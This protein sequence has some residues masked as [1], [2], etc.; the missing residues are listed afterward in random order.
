MKNY[1]L[2]I[3]SLLTAITAASCVKDNKDEEILPPEIEILAPWYCDTIYFDEEVTYRFRVTD[4]SGVGLGNFSMD[5][6]NNFNHHSHGSHISCDMDPQKDPVHPF[7]EVWIESLPD[8]QSDYLL[9]MDITIPL[10]KDDE[11]EH[12]QGDYH[13]HIYITNA[14]GY[15]TFT[16]FD[17]K[18]LKRED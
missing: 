5:I 16:S 6:H 17:I 10:M 15:Q 11:H 14:E 9:E 13:F 1:K 8:D 7:E 12:D 3:I 18:L 4:K 2:L